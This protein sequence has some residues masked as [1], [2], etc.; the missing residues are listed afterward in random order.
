VCVARVS[1]WAVPASL[2]SGGRAGQG[3]AWNVGQEDGTAW[4]V[5]GG[6][7][8]CEGGWVLGAVHPHASTPPPHPLS[9]FGR[10][11]LWPS[12]V[13]CVLGRLPK[14]KQ[15]LQHI[16]KTFGTLAF[17]RRWLERDDGGSFAVNG[18]KG[19]QDRYIGA[20]KVLCDAD[21]IVVRGCVGPWATSPPPG[22]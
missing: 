11:T 1:V 20:L 4:F 10:P 16:N 8:R 7:C 21:I 14:A 6:F 9:L 13:P 17:C 18:S 2:T 19:K 3:K 12:P 22:P 5:C 15:L